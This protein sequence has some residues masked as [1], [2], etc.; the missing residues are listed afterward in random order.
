M[1]VSVPKGGAIKRGGKVDVKVTVKRINGFTGPVTLSLPLPP[2]IV[3][4]TVKA[5]TIPADKTVGTLSIQ[6]AKNA[7]IG[8][9]ANMVVRGTMTFDGKAAVDAAVTLKV[10]K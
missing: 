6:A 10:A 7:T 9:L 1:T 2:G 5:V 4:V 8:T 3:G